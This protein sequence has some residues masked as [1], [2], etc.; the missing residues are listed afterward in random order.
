M[1]KIIWLY[2]YKIWDNWTFNTLLIYIYGRFTL[3]IKSA[4]GADISSQYIIITKIKNNNFFACNIKNVIKRNFIYLKIT[5]NIKKLKICLYV[6][7]S[8]KTYVKYNF[9]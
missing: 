3:I 7:V 8:L 5:K 9:F 1:C 2:L 4:I 6:I